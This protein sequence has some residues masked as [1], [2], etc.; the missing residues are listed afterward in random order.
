MEL[1]WEL[2]TREGNRHRLKRI[3]EARFRSSMRLPVSNGR[4]RSCSTTT[5]CIWKAASAAEIV[6]GLP[7]LEQTSLEAAEE[8]LDDAETRR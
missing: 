4:C 7:D 3:E 1:P 6:I 2:L 8:V 5:M